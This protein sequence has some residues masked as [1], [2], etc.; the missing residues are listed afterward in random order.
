M[1]AGKDGSQSDLGLFLTC[2]WVSTGGSQL[3]V[4]LVPSNKH[5]SP[6][7]ESTLCV[8]LCSYKILTQGHSHAESDIGLHQSLFQNAP[9]HTYLV[10]S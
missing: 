2:S 4:Q 6:A 5:M 1:N 7:E 3:S 10:A 8:S 9:K